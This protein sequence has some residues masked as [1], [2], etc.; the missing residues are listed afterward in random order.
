MIIADDSIGLLIIL[1]KKRGMKSFNEGFAIEFT[2]L[3]AIVKDSPVYLLGSGFGFFTAAHK[4]A[5]LLRIYKKLDIV[6]I[7]Q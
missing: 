4:E 1:I 5:L 2:A 6:R 3:T 7:P